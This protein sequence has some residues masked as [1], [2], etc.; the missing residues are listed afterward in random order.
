VSF[1]YLDGF[2]GDVA[3]LLY[4][5]I[6]ELIL[7]LQ[8][9]KVVL[10]GRRF[11]APLVQRDDL[12]PFVALLPTDHDRLLVDYANPSPGKAFLEVRAFGQGQVLVNG[13]LI[14]RWEGLLPRA[15]FFFFVDRAMIT[16]DEIFRVFWPDM[17]IR[18]ATNVFHVTKRKISEILSVGLTTYTSG[19]YR[20]SPDIDLHYDVVN[21]QEAIQR[22]AVAD[23]KCK[24]ELLL[25]AI[26]LYREEFLSSI[27][28]DW[29][30]R[31][32]DEMRNAY[33]DALIGLGRIYE[34]RG[35]LQYALGVFLRASG[36]APTREDLTRAI[37]RLYG[38]MKAPELAIEAYQR[39]KDML[40][41]TFNVLP[42]PQTDHLLQEIRKQQDN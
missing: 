12:R 24:E 18:E 20:I 28:A 2:D 41:Q 1:L 23:E 3:P 29:T 37:M 33:T 25:V 11:P 36:V 13:E 38:Q 39:L 9:L 34:R 7:R 21:F 4:P 16:R 32:R 15:L 42:D 5:I 27:D 6:I 14:D 35:D 40:K 22:A 8:K 26:D 31:R 30:K 10:S 17:A 19:F